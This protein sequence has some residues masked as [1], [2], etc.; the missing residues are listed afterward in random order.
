MSYLPDGVMFINEEMS[1]SD[2]LFRFHKNASQWARIP[3][4]R[5]AM[6]LP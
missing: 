1:W 5:E 3:R 4:E 6:Q 2:T